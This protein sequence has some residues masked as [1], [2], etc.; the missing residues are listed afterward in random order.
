[1]KRT[2]WAL[3]LGLLAFAP[4]LGQQK[5]T[6]A[7]TIKRTA[8]LV[9]VPTVVTLDGKPVMGLQVGDFVLLHNGKPVTGLTAKDFVLLH[10]GQP[11]LVEVF[12]EMD[13]T[14]AKVERVTLPPQSVQN[15]A[16]A[17]SRQDVIILFL[18]YLNATWSTRRRIHSFLGDITRQFAETRTPV[19]VFLLSNDGLKQLHSFASD[20]G[21]LTK[22]IERWQSGTVS[23]AEP[24]GSWASPFAPT[25][26]AQ[27]SSAV[28][29]LEPFH[30]TVGFV[31]LLTY[32]MN[33]R[34]LEMTLDAMKQISEAYRGVPGRKKLI[35]MSTGLPG[36][37][38][39]AS[40]YVDSFE[41]IF[42]A[43]SAEM[44]ARALKSLSNANMVVYPIDCNGVVNPDWETNFSPQNSRVPVFVAPVSIEGPS[45]TPSLLAFAEKT[46]GSLCTTF[47]N[48]C[49]A[50]V[51][52][53][54]N[55]YYVL[56]FYL[57]GD[58]KP[59]WHKL[60]VKVNQSKAGVRA[61]EGFLVDAAP[62]KAPTTG[63]EEVDT[64][65]ASPLD[66][67][68]VPLRLSWSVLS[69]QGKEVQV[70]FVLISPPGGIAVSPDDSRINLDYL[71]FVRPVGKTEGRTIPVTLTTWISP[72]QQKIFATSG[73]RFRKQVALPPGRYEVRVLLRD[74][75]SKKMG[76]VSTIVD[77][78][79]A[80]SAP[81]K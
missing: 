66:Y 31:P 34:K 78:S 20:L 80:S 2:F 6:P 19:S 36:G 16:P 60:K 69:A 7:P 15:Y 75:V 23:A 12:E 42:G 57:R 41:L 3:T 32:E 14:P 81:K 38:W 61:R 33:L 43:K 63:K 74:N 4:A 62:T 51:L 40:D 39:R 68:S 50:Q 67:T 28:R 73:F 53:D 37:K 48:K 45:N 47:P 24:L 21:N 64:A 17:E 44:L 58:N 18:D 65:L 77:L 79:P 30:E 5:E 59:G 56:G 29:G 46:G 55:H 71:A 11:E 52:S 9:L 13:A 22:A 49:V 76:T 35:W 25:D 72:D 10:N 70:E 54:G 26:M 27:T 1:M 8:E